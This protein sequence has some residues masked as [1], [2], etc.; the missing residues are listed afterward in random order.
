MRYFG[1]WLIIL[2]AFAGLGLMP[3]AAEV[4]VNVIPV[5]S[6]LRRVT[7]SLSVCVFGCRTTPTAHCVCLTLF[8]SHAVRDC[9]MFHPKLRWWWL[10]D[11]ISLG[12][13]KS[14]SLL[15]CFY[16]LKICVRSNWSELD[17]ILFTKSHTMKNKNIKPLTYSRFRCRIH[18]LFFLQFSGH[19]H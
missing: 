8:M 16:R 1:V 13:S 15:F 4:P 9:L 10:K 18:K 17:L 19:H 2:T 3:C 5:T 14:N 6:R 11:R 12:F 7:D